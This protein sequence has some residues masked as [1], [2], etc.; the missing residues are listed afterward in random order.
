MQKLAIS[1]PETSYTQKEAWDIFKDSDVEQ[2]LRP[3]S[4]E[5]VRKVLNGNNGIEKRHFAL[6]DFPHLL[7]ADGEV[8]NKA[9]EIKAPELAGQA[10][11][12]A[13][14]EA[15]WSAHD[16][17]ALIVCS[18]TGYLCPGLSSFIAEDLSLKPD[19]YMIDLVGQGCGA[20]VPSIRAAHNFLSAQKEARVAV[21]AVEVCTAAFYLDDE[22]GVLISFC[23]FGDGAAASL[24]SNNV[25]GS[26]GFSATGFDS[27]H[28]PENREILRFENSGGMLRNR[29]HPSIPEKSSAAVE[30]LYNKAFPNGTR[31][32]RIISHGGGIK[33]LDAL[34]EKLPDF[35]FVEARETLRQYGNMSSPS[36][37]F[38][39]DEFLSKGGSDPHLWL[40]SFGAGFT[41]HSMSL[42]R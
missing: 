30:A 37:L 27:V 39:L 13:L 15:D 10:L 18:C 17:D 11:N 34:K 35:D 31:P 21:V 8:L 12:K 36:V 29:L 19:I 5:L 14:N 4:I 40:T 22:A 1:V 25:K 32:D 28:L 24:W 41:A 9:F 16:L 33:V 2:K 3:G 42:V 20:A 38:A 7:K 26:T 23:I 6:S